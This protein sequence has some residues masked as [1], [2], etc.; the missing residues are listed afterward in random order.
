MAATR[1]ARSSFAQAFRSAAEAT[2]MVARIFSRPLPAPF[3]HVLATLEGKTWHSFAPRYDRSER[4]HSVFWIFIAVIAATLLAITLKNRGVVRVIGAVLLAGLLLFGVVLRLTT[5]DTQVQAERGRPTSPA[6]AVT[7]IPVDQIEIDGLQLTGGGA[8]FELRGKVRNTSA[9]TRV[10]SITLRIVRR[11]CYEEAIDPS[12]CAAIWQDQ[13]WIAV[14]VPPE[15]QRTFATTFYAR[16]PVSKLRG[17]LKDE[18]TLIAA[19]GD[20]A[21]P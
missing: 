8:P 19:T 2:W 7:A 12:G 18:F 3:L 17:T 13:H 1:F 6:T 5:D 21:D 15:E 11:D 4:A 20:S 14:N 16:T 9:D 10:R